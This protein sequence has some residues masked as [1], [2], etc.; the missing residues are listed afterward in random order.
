MW[1]CRQVA[2]ALRDNNYR[3]LPWYR[4]AGL[5][6][7]VALCC[8]CGRYHQQ[9]MD[10]QDGARKFVEVEEDDSIPRSRKLSRD[11]RKRI[12]DTMNRE[13]PTGTK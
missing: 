9:V 4:R 13:D 3:E 8:F 2:T 1:M 10:L 11:A 12:E 6:F 5:R 7:H